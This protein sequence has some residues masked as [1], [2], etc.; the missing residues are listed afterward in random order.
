VASKLC[1]E[2]KSMF[3]N[4]E[5]FNRPAATQAGKMPFRWA[6]HACLA[7]D[8]MSGQGPHCKQDIAPLPR[9]RHHPLRKIRKRR[10]DFDGKNPCRPL[11]EYRARGR[12]GPVRTPR[13]GRRYLSL[14]SAYYLHQPDRKRLPCSTFKST[15]RRTKGTIAT[16]RLHRHIDL[17][18]RLRRCDPGPAARDRHGS[19][20]VEQACNCTVPALPRRICNDARILVSARHKPCARRPLHPRW[21]SRLQDRG[22]ER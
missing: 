20:P 9:S 4:R 13:S 16:G 8:R 6:R 3:L 12:G 18:G 7:G 17:A 1:H 11:I 21:S 10:G 22:A 5:S 2:L 19:G 14:I 15:G